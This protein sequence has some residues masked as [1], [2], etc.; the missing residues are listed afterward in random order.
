MLNKLKQTKTKLMKDR[1]DVKERLLNKTGTDND[2]TLK[3]QLTL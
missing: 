2:T 1:R 3:H